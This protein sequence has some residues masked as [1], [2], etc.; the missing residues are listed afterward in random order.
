MR[1]IPRSGTRECSDLGSRAADRR[2]CI[3][4]SAA[5]V[6]AARGYVWSMRSLG[7]Y[8]DLT[9]AQARSQWSQIQRRQQRPRQEPYTP[10]EVILCY[11]LF[12]LINPHDYR[13]GTADLAPEIVHDLARLFKRS[14]GS[15]TSKMKNLDGSLA[16]AGA[17]EWLFFA[18]MA[19]DTSQFP[20]LYSR[21]L[22]A[23]RDMGVGPGRLPDFLSLEDG[24]A[25]DLLGQDE[26]SQRTLDAVVAVR[27][28][29]HRAKL[30]T[31]DVTNDVATSR[32]AEHQIRLGQHRFARSVLANYRHC[33]A[34]CGFAPR[35]LLGHRLLVASH[36]KPWAECD[37][38]ER[39]DSRNGIAACGLHDAAFD[40]GLITVNGG[41]RVHR[42]QRLTRSLRHDPGVD[43]YFG[44][45]LQPKLLLPTGAVEPSDI[46]LSWHRD[47]IYVGD[48]GV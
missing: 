10:V 25:F 38:K 29:R 4:V 48:A 44:M 40:T 35:S 6:L 17:H 34:F 7:D 21:V 9:D 11:G 20:Q 15:I 26:L 13:G 46:Y 42:A 47:H 16:H 33:C 30:L 37:D 31:S 27:A 32:L 5:A 45:A 12:R 3:A 19:A 2:E 39:L 24:D 18:E 43:R 8:V 1:R 41:M 36:I 28:A 14:P 22:R 23:A